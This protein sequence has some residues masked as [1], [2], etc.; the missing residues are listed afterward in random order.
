M[1]APSDRLQKRHHDEA[2]ERSLLIATLEATA[3]G[4]LVVDHAGKIVR[5]NERFAKLWRVPQAILDSAD[6]D[7][8]IAY[9]LSQLKDPDA[10]VSKVREL[11]AHPDSD[12][13][14]VLEFLD[15]RV[16]ERYSIPQR[17]EGH[18]V[19]RVWSFRDVTQRVRE[20][21]ERADVEG[22]AR[23]RLD[24]LESLWRLLTD[25]QITGRRL[26][27]TILSEGRRA[28]E[29]DYATL[30][31]IDGGQVLSDAASPADAVRPGKAVVQLDGT[32]ASLVLEAD[33]TLHSS[34]LKTDPT[35]AGDRRIAKSRLRAAIATPMRI[36]ERTFV[37]GFGS[38]KPR[39]EPF[40]V[41]D[42]E[43]VELLAAYFGRLLRL[44][45]QEDEI[46]HLAYHDALTGLE[47]RR[48]CLERLD[49]TIVRSRRGKR[50]FA[51]MFIDLD[52]FKEVNDALGHV[53]G[54]AVLLEAGRRLKSVV[55]SED[56]SARFGG[57]EFA[58]LMVETEGPMET[59][60]LAHRIVDAM[61]VPFAFEGRE[62]QVSASIGIAVHPD[63]GSTASALLGSA[64][65]ALYRAKEQGRGRICFYSEDIAARLHLRRQMQN[66]LRKAVERCEFDL[67]YQPVVRLADGSIDATEALLR[68][69]HPERGIV[70]PSEFI[71]IAEDTGLMVPIGDWVIRSATAQLGEWYRKGRRWRMAINIS[72]VQLQDSLFVAQLTAAIEAAGV[73][74]DLIE[75][76]VTESAA[77]RDPD[78]AQA[79]LAECRRLG[80]RVALDDFGTHYASL[81]H[82]K[83]L[84][85]DIIKIDRSFVRGLPD[86]PNDAAIVRSVLALGTNFGCSVVAEGV[87]NEDQARWLRE[88]GCTV[89]QGFLLARPMDAAAL[90]R[91]ADSIAGTRV[92]PE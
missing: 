6:D 17:A 60:E 79:I 69:N 42:R 57:D 4:I 62:L 68:W 56:M 40:S 10:F 9:V 28:L 19:G 15:G 26:A 64:D 13:F 27:E 74:S 22:K 80:M 51:L 46:T 49:E 59:D 35:Y 32:L 3:D 25:S 86:D 53:A 52:R 73:P 41:E 91:W 84:P 71:P 54:D 45:E 16:F 58:V 29:L 14:D 2:L 18:A 44:R 82:L 30:S 31:R 75:I 72:A 37:L 23:R 33:E 43:Y 78:A 38:R 63:D 47:N 7:R 48:R 24:R 5:F 76:E 85:V 11:Y 36:G 34:D 88:N 12:S 65:A 50:R 20:E 89:G 67:L 81:S 1:S 8:A 21:R 66:G 83:K 92:A 90:D 77:L 39:K 55:R 61:A 70:F 87:E